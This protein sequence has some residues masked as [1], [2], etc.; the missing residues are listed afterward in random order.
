MNMNTRNSAIL[1]ATVVSLS[2]GAFENVA[3]ARSWSTCNTV[4]KKWSSP[5]ISLRARSSDFPQGSAVR[6]KLI[7][8]FAI[9]SNTASKVQYAVSFDVNQDIAFSEYDVANGHSEIFFANIQE[10]AVTFTWTVNQTCT[11]TEADVLIKSSIDWTASND[12]DDW[13]SYSGSKR[14]L[15][16]VLLHELGHVQGLAHNATTY[17]IMGEDYK[18]AR[19]NDGTVRGYA[20]E[21]DVDESIDVYGL[22]SGS[23]EDLAVTHWKHIGSTNH[24]EGAYGLFGRTRPIAEGSGSIYSNPGADPVFDIVRGQQFRFE[25]TLENLGKSDQVANV[26][27]YLSS[28]DNITTSDTFLG[29]HGKV[30]LRDVP[31][32]TTS[33]VLTI[34]EHLT[35]GAE[36]W[37]GAIVDYDMAIPEVNE[38]NNRTRAAIRIMAKPEDMAALSV[39]GPNTQIAGAQTLVSFV[40]ENLGDEGSP[41]YDY[42]IRLSKNA[43]ITSYDPLVRAGSSQIHGFQL[44]AVTIPAHLEPGNYYW[45]LMVKP[46]LFEA[47]VQ[48]NV[49]AGNQIQVTG[50]LG[51][52]PGVYAQQ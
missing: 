23:F 20:G 45:G 14:P 12:E 13:M 3:D 19:A 35:I 9:W 41:Q 1:V 50:V 24:V 2:F 28:N 37:I 31:S 43:T 42:E 18:H 26:A 21:A 47:N 49:K 10:P 38:W 36:Y 29:S 40:V 11:I 32:T 33:P 52:G 7:D 39:L 5:N 22:R 27:Y 48:N 17:S 25:V 51:Q 15:E 34:P 4:K 30:I 16:T 8:S 6:Q 44:L 46:K